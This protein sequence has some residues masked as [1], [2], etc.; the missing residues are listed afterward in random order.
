MAVKILVSTGLDA[1]K[2]TAVQRALT[3]SNPVLENLQ[4]VRVC[5]VVGM[6]A[7]EA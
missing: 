7:L 3:L 4:K 6:D 1:C 2:D 5:F